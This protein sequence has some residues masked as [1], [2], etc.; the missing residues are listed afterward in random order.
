LLNS[1]SVVN[2]RQ[3]C[4]GPRHESVWGS[5]GMAPR[6]LKLVDRCLTR[7]EINPLYTWGWVGP[8]TEGRCVMNQNVIVVIV[9]SLWAGRLRVL[10]PTWTRIFLSPGKRHINCGSQPASCL[11]GNGDSFPR[12]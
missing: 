8:R 1:I 6:I 12:V 5:R 10:F 9:K 11:A 3:S 4:S 7:Q 2:E